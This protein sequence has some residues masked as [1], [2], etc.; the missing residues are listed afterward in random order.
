MSLALMAESVGHRYGD[1]VALSDISFEVRAGELLMLLGPNGA[2]KSTLFGLVTQ[3]L[4][5]GEGRIEVGGHP[6]GSAAARRDL[7][8]VFQQPTLDLDLGVEQNLR[9]HGALHGLGGAEL[10][11]RLEGLLERFGLSDRR[12]DRVRDLNGGHRRRVE[13]ARALLHRPRLL[14]LDEPTVGLDVQTRRSFVADLHGLAESEG[15]AVLWATHLIDEVAETDSVIV[16]HRGQIRARG[17]PEALRKRTG[18]DTLEAAFLELTGASK[19]V[20]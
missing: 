7:G 5:L 11:S 12:S 18:A 10:R 20:A 6:W 9:Y 4:G 15:M 14:L 16:L 3:L 13:L 1:K 19:A 8:V 2:G 17:V